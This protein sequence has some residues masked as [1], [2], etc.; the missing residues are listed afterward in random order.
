M[1]KK[2][3]QILISTRL[4]AMLFLVYGAALAMGTFVETWYNTDTAKIWIY[5]AWWFELIMVLFVVNFI[6]NIGRYRLLKREN[7]AVFVLHAS[8][9]F[10]IVGAGVTRYISDEGKLAL[11]E[12]EEADFYTSELTYI[13]AQVD[14]TYEGQPLRKAKQTEVLFSEFT[15]NNYNW[16]SDFKGKDFHIE[17]TRFIANAEESFVE[18]PSGEDYLKIVESSGGE[19][20]E[21]YL[22]A[23]TTQ[24]L[25]GL[26][27]SLNKPTEGAIN[28]QITPEGSYISTPYIGSYMTMTD[29]KV[30]TV[31]KDSMQPLQYRCLYN[32]GGMRFVL[33]EPLKKGKMVM[34]SIA[35]NKRTAAD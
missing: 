23:G 28:L 34:A 7:W 21:H 32:I 8:W 30:F 33:P 6:G 22:K 29:Q 24:E 5:N 20:H 35:A 26:L 15:S 19:G 13:T 18:D 17:L 25:H 16:A 3:T 9:I 4:M 2:L 1:L 11:R 12:G 10:I 31:A 14:G 27:I